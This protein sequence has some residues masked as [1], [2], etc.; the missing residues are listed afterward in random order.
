MGG[1][2]ISKA[3]YGIKKDGDMSDRRL[4]DATRQLKSALQNV[5]WYVT[6]QLE[7]EKSFRYDAKAIYEAIERIKTERPDISKIEVVLGFNTFEDLK[8]Y[9]RSEVFATAIVGKY[10]FGEA[11]IGDMATLTTGDVF[12][13]LK[14]IPSVRQYVAFY[15]ADANYRDVAVHGNLKELDID[16]S[17][18]VREP[19][20]TSAD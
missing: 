3:L 19:T 10:A 6:E 1:K 17:Q 8:F 15:H 5:M 2:H 7:H 16:K 9:L 14:S 4:I 13:T 12:V 11:A 18:L 20:K